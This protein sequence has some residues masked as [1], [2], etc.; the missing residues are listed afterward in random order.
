MSSLRALNGNHWHKGTRQKPVRLGKRNR[1]LQ[2]CFP[3]IL[4]SRPPLCPSHPISFFLSCSLWDIFQSPTSSVNSRGSLQSW[5]IN[6]R[7]MESSSERC[8]GGQRGKDKFGFLTMLEA[9]GAKHSLWPDCTVLLRKASP[10]RIFSLHSLSFFASTGTELPTVARTWVLKSLPLP[11][12]RKAK[13]PL[14]FSSFLGSVFLQMS[15]RCLENWVF[16]GLEFVVTIGCIYLHL[17]KVL[18]FFF[19][20]TI[21]KFSFKG[22]VGKSTSFIYQVVASDTVSGYLSISLSLSP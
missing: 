22:Y 17:T 4:A 5:S 6:L 11:P 13:P 3:K 1:L 19:F 10:F 14:A 20:K 18:F 12:G 8:L 16:N 9:D 7:T 2:R 15:P 21:L